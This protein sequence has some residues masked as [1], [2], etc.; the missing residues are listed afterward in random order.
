MLFQ[1]YFICQA[2]E[3]SL[4]P[5]TANST[6]IINNK[7]HPQIEP[8]PTNHWNADNITGFSQLWRHRKQLRSPSRNADGEKLRV[9]RRMA[10][11]GKASRNFHK[12]IQWCGS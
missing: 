12:W 4:A 8:L 7:I 5:K 3:K 6:I 2:L 1:F 10:T 9:L 11:K